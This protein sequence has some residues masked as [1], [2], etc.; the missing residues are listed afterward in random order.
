MGRVSR[1]EREGCRI[2]AGRSPLKEMLGPE[3]W[4]ISDKD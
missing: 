1:C 4:V 2:V 3:K